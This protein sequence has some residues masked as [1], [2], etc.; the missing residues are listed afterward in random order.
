MR[1]AT[2][3]ELKE[4]TI[5]DYM[6][7]AARAGR[8]MSIG[9]AERLAL[10][11]CQIYDAVTREQRAPQAPAAPDPAK[12]AEKAAALDVEAAKV[13]AEVDH[14]QIKTRR[15]PVA[16]LHKRHRKDS[17]AAFVKGRINRIISGATPSRDF[18]VACS[19]AECP[20]LAYEVMTMYANIVTRN[21]PRRAI[22]E[23]NPFAGMTE[24]DA[25]RMS[26]A[27]LENICDRSSG[28]LGPWWV[29]K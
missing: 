24:R 19:T 8:S 7:D 27:I 28:R 25:S 17:R 16:T 15:A 1:L 23:P 4:I 11:D 26:M 10:R 9:Q 2:P 6:R 21:M 3:N 14:G 12:V 5:R 13:G 22:D 20:D 29:P 18:K